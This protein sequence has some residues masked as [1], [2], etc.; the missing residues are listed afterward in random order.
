MYPTPRMTEFLH[1]EHPEWKVFDMQPGVVA[2][3]MARQAARKAPDRPGLA[4][5]LGRVVGGE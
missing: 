5:G 2:T 4:A 3:E 1:H